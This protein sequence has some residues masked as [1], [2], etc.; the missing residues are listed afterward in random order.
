MERVA[1][2]IANSITTATAAVWKI[3]LIV[4]VSATVKKGWLYSTGWHSR[5]KKTINNNNHW[6][7]T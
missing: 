2:G 4:I 7:C 3:Q 6:R 5:K 1:A